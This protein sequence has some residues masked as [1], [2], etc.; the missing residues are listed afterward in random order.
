ME[1]L[2]H[3][4]CWIQFAIVAIQSK[5]IQV[6]DQRGQICCAFCQESNKMVMQQMQEDIIMYRGRENGIYVTQMIHQY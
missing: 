4:V 1:L 2:Q 6:K 3:L 5:E